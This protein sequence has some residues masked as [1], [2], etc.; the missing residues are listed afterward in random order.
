MVYRVFS[1]LGFQFL[2]INIESLLEKAMGESL[3]GGF[4]QGVYWNLSS[5]E[6]HSS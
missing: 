1:T 3:E 5:I 4:I 6:D 2:V